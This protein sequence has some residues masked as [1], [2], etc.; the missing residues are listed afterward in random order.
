MVFIMVITGVL[1]LMAFKVVH[2]TILELGAKVSSR[3]VRWY[4]LK[5]KRM[6]GTPV[7]TGTIFIIVNYKSENGGWT[8]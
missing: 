2:L 5:P 3:I 7:N 6:K 4:I 8:G 1:I